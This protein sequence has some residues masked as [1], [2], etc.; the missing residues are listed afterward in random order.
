MEFRDRTWEGKERL[1]LPSS[2]NFWIRN[3]WLPRGTDLSSRVPTCKFLC[4]C[5][6][7]VKSESNSYYAY[8]VWNYFYTYFEVLLKNRRPSRVSSF[9]N[10]STVTFCLRIGNISGSCSEGLTSMSAIREIVFCDRRKKDWIHKPHEPGLIAV[11]PHTKSFPFSNGNT[12]N[13]IK[14]EYK[15]IGPR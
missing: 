8:K 5:V 11:V 7:G 15:Y 10:V 12:D 14:R 6:P 13:R 3:E 1:S 2:V 4:I 9:T